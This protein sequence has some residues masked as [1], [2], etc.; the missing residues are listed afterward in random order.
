MLGQKVRLAT[1][2]IPRSTAIL[3]ERH[4]SKLPDQV[5]HHS[6]KSTDFLGRG[7]PSKKWKNGGISALGARTIFRLSLRECQPDRE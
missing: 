3:P 2:L 6:E 5:R 4:P 1:P 7:A